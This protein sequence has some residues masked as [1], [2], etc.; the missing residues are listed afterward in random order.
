MDW[1]KLKGRLLFAY[2]MNY[3]F[4]FYNIFWKNIS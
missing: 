4:D 2:N 3:K 1:N